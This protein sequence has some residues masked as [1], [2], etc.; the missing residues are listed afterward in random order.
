MP[1]K[2][3]KRT[4]TS[5]HK[6]A[7][8]HGREQSR[9]VRDYLKAL[10]ANRPK[11]GRKRSPDSVKKQL[12]AVEASLATATG[13]ARLGLVQKR[14]DLGL[15]LT[16]LHKKVDLSPLERLFVK[17]AKAYGAAK[18]IA[19]PTWRDVG[20]PAAVLQKAGITRRS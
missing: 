4:M 6:E 17:H 16:A 19:Y 9:A 20:V 3:R 14:R 13:T 7:L 5:A 18:R 8:A 11:R 15:E 12:A 10:E 2:P 1:A